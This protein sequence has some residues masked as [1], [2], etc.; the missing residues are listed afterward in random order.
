M[1]NQP[2]NNN[3]HFLTETWITLVWQNPLSHEQVMVTSQNVEELLLAAD[4]FLIKYVKDK[5]C[6]FL[7]HRLVPTNCIGIRH[8]ARWLCTALFPFSNVS[9]A[10]FYQRVTLAVRTCISA[11]FIFVW[12]CYAPEVGKKRSWGQAGAVYAGFRLWF[13]REKSTFCGGGVSFLN[14][15]VCKFRECLKLCGIW[16]E[17]ILKFSNLTEE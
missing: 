8:T 13:R 4:Q 7:R 1:K 16:A 5:C 6:S 12:G 3:F 17:S 11:S 15:N 9:V 10:L 14:K 2:K